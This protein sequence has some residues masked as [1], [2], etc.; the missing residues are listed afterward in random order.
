M[1]SATSP[2][3]SVICSPTAARNTLG[4][5]VRVRAGVEERRHQRVRVELAAGSRACVPSFHD[6][7]IARI[8]RMNSRM[9][10]AGCDHG[11]ENRFSMCGLIWLPRPRM[12]RPFEYA[13]QVVGRCTPA[14]SACGR[15]RPR[16]PVPSSMRSVCSAASTSGRNGS[17]LVSAV[18]AAVVAERLERRAARSGRSASK[19]PAISIAVDLHVAANSIGAHPLAVTPPRYRPIP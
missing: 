4:G 11:I 15:T 17:W 19:R 5:A 14:S 13:L 12:K 6:A 18:S 1:P 3:T 9:R 10:G 7:Q 16:S 8:A 2:A